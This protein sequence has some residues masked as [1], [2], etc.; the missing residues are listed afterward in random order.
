MCAIR[1]AFSRSKV[2]RVYFWRRS[3][4]MLCLFFFHPGQKDEDFFWGDRLH[5]WLSL[6]SR[7]S[8]KNTRPVENRWERVPIV[9]RKKR[10]W[11]SA[12]WWRTIVACYVTRCFPIG[13]KPWPLARRKRDLPKAAAA[14]H[15]NPAPCCY[16]FSSSLSFSLMIPTGCNYWNACPSF[17]IGKL[18]SG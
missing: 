14:S 9:V 12:G 5:L 16:R 1:S 18:L 13:L 7:W 2:S 4:L 8:R 15:D 6:K 3:S 11:E 17:C 10:R